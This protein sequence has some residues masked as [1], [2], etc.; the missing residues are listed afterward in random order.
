MVINVFTGVSTYMLLSS[1]SGL[2]G[3]QAYLMTPMTIISQH[4]SLE[5]YVFKAKNDSTVAS[6]LEIFLSIQGIKRVALFTVPDDYNEWRMYRIPLPYGTY[7]IVFSGTVG[8]SLESDLGLAHVS[9]VSTP[10]T[11]VP[12]CESF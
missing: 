7:R 2:T 1:S 9:L 6:H 4:N 10:E 12:G 8:S 11:E 5:F 3:Q